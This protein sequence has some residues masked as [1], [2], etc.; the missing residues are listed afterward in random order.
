[1]RRALPRLG[2]TTLHENP[3]APA[4]AASI[5]AISILRIVIIA[6]IALLAAAGSGC[7]SA[8]TNARGVICHENPHRSL[9]QPQSLS[10]SPL[11]TIEFQ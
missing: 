6:S 11:P 8:A 3:A 9:R 7:W 10:A 5:T 1:M 2:R 4:T